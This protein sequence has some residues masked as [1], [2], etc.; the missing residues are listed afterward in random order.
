MFLITSPDEVPVNA[1]FKVPAD[2]FGG[3]VSRDGFQPASH[4]ARFHWVTVKDISA[5]SLKEWKGLIN[6]SYQLV[7]ARLPASQRARLGIR[8]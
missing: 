1:S 4:L 6:R 3:L 7:A 8:G 2:E 5:V